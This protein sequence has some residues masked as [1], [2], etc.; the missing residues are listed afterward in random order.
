MRRILAMAVALLV[1][2]AALAEYPELRAVKSLAESSLK[3][4]ATRMRFVD[5]RFAGVINFGEAILSQDEDRPQSVD[6][7]TCRSQ[8]YWRAMMEMAPNDP[9]VLFAQAYL[10]AKEGEIDRAN[11]YM[12]L[13]GMG[14]SET[15]KP[16]FAQWQ[17]AYKA[18][19]KRTEG[20]VAKGI[21]LN[22]NRKYKK[23]IDVYDKV[24]LEYPYSST[25][26]YEKAFTLLLMDVKGALFDPGHIAMYTFCRT[27]NPFLAEAYQ[28]NDQKVIQGA[29]AFSKKVQPFL[30]GQ[31]RTIQ[32]FSAF[33]DGCEEMGL[34]DIAA[35]CQWRL[36]LLDSANQKEHIRKYLQLIEQ[37]GCPNM[38]F[39]R[40]QFSLSTDEK[41]SQAQEKPTPERN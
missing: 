37:A 3:K 23:A 22:D 28:G 41:P 17:V 31:D 13:G 7:L 26:M 15:F 24:L 8:D 30:A 11:I 36:V 6:A 39:F 38:K 4:T 9:S 32:G 34:F 19:Y 14:L 12:N 10:L 18:L 27:H 20:E 33:A 40:D 1:G 5:I 29:I 2:V 16:E 25:A 21:K 35:I